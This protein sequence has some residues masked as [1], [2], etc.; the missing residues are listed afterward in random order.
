MKVWNIAQF[1]NMCRTTPR[2]LR[3]YE[4]KGI[5]TPAK[6][7]PW[8]KYRF[9][10]QDQVKDFLQIKLLQSFHVPLSSMKKQHALHAKDI[11]QNQIK[12]LEKELEEKKREIQFLQNM[13][14]LFFDVSSVGKLLH[15]ETFG[16]HLLFTKIIKNADYHKVGEYITLLQGVAQKH[17]I[18]VQKEELVFYHTTEFEPKNTT[19]EVA[20]LLKKD[21]HTIPEGCEVKKYPATKLLV[22]DY[23][24]P[25]EYFILIY[26]KLFAYLMEKNIQLTGNAFDY[27]VQSQERSDSIYKIHTKLCFPV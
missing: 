9:Y 4:E 1:A 8:T 27:Y 12:A 3:F 23:I 16:P 24:G 7:D 11:V 2:T 26:Q 25:Y 6:I 14:D 5:F 20:L 15:K 13:Q 18:A 22:Y 19:I 10:S 17:N 21:I